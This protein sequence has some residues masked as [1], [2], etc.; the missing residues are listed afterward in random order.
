MHRNTSVSSVN[1]HRGSTGSGVFFDPTFSSGVKEYTSSRPK[2]RRESLFRW[3]Y[4]NVRRCAELYGLFTVQC[5]T[6][7]L[8]GK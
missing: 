1:E 4:L 2:E 8:Y 5:I 6:V 7:N 3:H